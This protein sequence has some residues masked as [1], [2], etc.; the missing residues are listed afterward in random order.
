MKRDIGALLNPRSVAVVGAAPVGQGLRGRILEFMKLHPYA[1][2]IYPVS[3]SHKE[4]Q[5]LAAYPS[6]GDCPGPVDLAILIVPAKFVPSELEACGKAGVKAAAIISSGFAEEPG[7]AGA[8]MQAE[9]KAIA[10]RY[11]MAV[12]GP[13]SE[14]FASIDANLLPTFSPVAGPSAV[15]LLPANRSN[16]RVALVAQSGG[17][18]FSFF[19]RGRP[20]EMAFDYIVTTGNEACLEGLEIVEHLLDAGKTDAFLMMIEDIKTP[21]TFLRVA[22]KALR[23]GKPLIVNKI[24]KTDAGARAAASHTAA[25]AGSYSAFQ[26]IAQRYGV[27]EG[28]QV[29][30]M[31]DIANGFMCWRDRLPRGKRIGICTGSGGGGAWLSDACMSAGLE[32]PTLDAATRAILDPLLPSYGTSQNPVDG[33]AQ[34]IRQIGYVGLA[35]PLVESPVID[36]VICIM[37]ARSAEGLTHEKEKLKALKAT[38]KKPILMWSYTLPAAASVE[39]LSGAGFPLYTNMQNV[40]TTMRHMGEWNVLRER[41]LKVPEVRTT[42]AS[43]RETVAAALAKSGPVLSEASSKPILQAYGLAVGALEKLATSR[44]EAI[45]AQRAIGGPVALKVQSPDILHKTEAG[46]VALGAASADQVAAAYDRITASAKAYKAGAKVEGVLVQAM[47]KKGREVILGINRDPHFGPMLMLGLGG[48][49][50]EV[51]KDVVFAPVPISRTDAEML[52]G[53]LKGAALLGPV[54]GQPAADKAAL[55]DMIVRLSELAA[56]QKDTIAEID[57]NPVIVHAEG[58]GATIADALIVKV[59]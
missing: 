24:G 11:G 56:D 9:L 28:A 59:Q 29:E 18:G 15:P 2:K 19:D 30:E 40:V 34:A 1:G 5:G 10:T 43:A 25:L 49:H 51:L 27:I 36:G 32:V 35:G 42:A 23:A 46:A 6:I 16:G 7:E 55:A 26:A 41:F 8:R 4:V 17:M 38:A 54:R 37:S 13:N 14:G 52:I 57:L 50:V 45:A 21:E 44:D 58:D 47:A 33:T 31:V 20:K 12:T 39:V 3:R 22:E 53:R 48:I